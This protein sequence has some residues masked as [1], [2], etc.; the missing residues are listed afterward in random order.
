[1]HDAAHPTQLIL[2]TR[3]PGDATPTRSCRAARVTLPHWQQLRATA[4]GRRLKVSRRT[5]RIAPASKARTVVVYVTG[6]LHGQPRRTTR[7]VLVCGRG[8]HT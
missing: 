2:G 1:M 4:R 7:H 3:L 6:R 8:R 5:V